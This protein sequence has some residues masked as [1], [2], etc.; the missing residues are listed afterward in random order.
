MICLGEDSDT[1]LFVEAAATVK[2]SEV[3]LR[4]VEI[5][6]LEED[7]AHLF[8]NDSRLSPSIA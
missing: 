1:D 2:I 3:A 7:T 6:D 5:H 8:L 4:R